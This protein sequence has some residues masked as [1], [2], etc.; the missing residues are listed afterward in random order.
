MI[1]L[2]LMKRKLIP[3]ESKP[4]QC[5]MH[6]ARVTSIVDE[7]SSFRDLDQYHS[8]IS[9]QY[10][11]Q[12]TLQKAALMIAVVDAAPPVAPVVPPVVPPT[13]F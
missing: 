8:P 6:Q 4:R 1:S 13:Q 10:S 12:P 5:T 2:L 11:V 9:Q 3:T 7:D